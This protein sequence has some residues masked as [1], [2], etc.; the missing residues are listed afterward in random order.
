MTLHQHRPA[1]F[2][3]ISNVVATILKGFQCRTMIPMVLAVVI[4]LSFYRTPLYRK[5]PVA[6][7]VIYLRVGLQQ[8]DLYR[9]QKTRGRL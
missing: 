6:A 9:M 4:R 8:E 1:S 2:V 3:V 5:I 7:W